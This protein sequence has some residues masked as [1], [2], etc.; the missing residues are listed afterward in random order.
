MQYLIEIKF[1]ASEYKFS[2]LY[3]IYNFFDTDR[4][5]FYHISYLGVLKG[6]LKWGLTL[7]QDNLQ[8]CPCS[9]F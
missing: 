5:I 4:E 1:D 3:F 9:H 8:K 7:D 2:K 6:P